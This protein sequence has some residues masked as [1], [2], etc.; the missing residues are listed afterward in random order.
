MKRDNR[1]PE[2]TARTGPYRQVKRLGAKAFQQP[3]LV[4]KAG[5][6]SPRRSSDGRLA[7]RET[8]DAVGQR[9]TA[10]KPDQL[11]HR[12]RIRPADRDGPPP[13]PA[14]QVAV[15]RQP[16]GKFDVAVAGSGHKA[17]PTGGKRG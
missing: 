17:R 15:P 5:P 3:P 16:E 11:T 8:R 6:P 13:V 12:S 9:Q 1:P 4:R 7:S 2:A 10:Q 14:S